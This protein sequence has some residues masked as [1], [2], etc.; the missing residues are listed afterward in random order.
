MTNEWI[1]KLSQSQIYILNFFKFKRIELNVAHGPKRPSTLTSP[2]QKLLGCE[3]SVLMLTLEKVWS[4][5][6][7]E[8]AGLLH[9][10]L[11]RTRWHRSV[12]SHALLLLVWAAEAPESWWWNLRGKKV[13]SLPHSSIHTCSPSHVCKGRLRCGAGLYTRVVTGSFFHSLIQ[14][15]RLQIKLGR[16]FCSLLILYVVNG[17]ILVQH[18]STMSTQI[19]LYN[20]LLTHSYSLFWI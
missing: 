6:A 5:A 18:L 20:M 12:T 19:T 10:Q 13:H 3:V 4:S 16:L 14:Y 9:C 17:L 1:Q 8:S 15:S 2:L 7:P 11:L